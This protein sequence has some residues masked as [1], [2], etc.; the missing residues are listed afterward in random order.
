VSTKN[1]HIRHYKSLSNASG[2]D[3]EKTQTSSI[4]N[5][6]PLRVNNNCTN[7]NNGQININNL[8]NGKNPRATKFAA[9]FMEKSKVIVSQTQ[10]RAK[11]TNTNK[12]KHGV[13]LPQVKIVVNSAPTDCSKLEKLA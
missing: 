8:N 7:L 3:K 6:A 5:A 13:P 11:S 2:D 12:A 1:S 10:Q 4:N 9:S